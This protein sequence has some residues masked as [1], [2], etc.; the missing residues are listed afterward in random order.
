MI[1]KHDWK[2]STNEQSGVDFI[3]ERSKENEKKML[4]LNTC[5]WETPT[6]TNLIA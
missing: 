4:R 3:Y 2:Q 6:N 1:K 5:A